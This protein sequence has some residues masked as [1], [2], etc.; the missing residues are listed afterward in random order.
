MI[1]AK[2]DTSLFNL[3]PPVEPVP[4]TKYYKLIKPWEYYP[5]YWMPAGWIFDGASIPSGL[6]LI[7]SAT[8]NPYEPDIMGPAG[9]HDL[10]FWLWTSLNVTLKEANE[11]LR[12]LLERNQKLHIEGKSGIKKFF[13]EKKLKSKKG[14][15]KISVDKFGGKY[16][17]NDPQDFIDLANCVKLPE[18]SKIPLE[19]FHLPKKTLEILAAENK[20]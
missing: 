12:A 16:W 15:I 5:G 1:I 20:I 18:N 17:E 11:I 14:L 9:I 8:Y 2:F 10:I 3:K 4:G 6:G 7:W 13:L 19:L